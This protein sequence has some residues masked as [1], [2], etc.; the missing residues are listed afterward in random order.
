MGVRTMYLCAY[1]YPCALS[2]IV[3]KGQGQGHTAKDYGQGQLKYLV[4]IGRIGLDMWCP[5][6]W[7]QIC[8]AQMCGAVVPNMWCHGAKN[9]VPAGAVGAKIFL[10]S[11]EIWGFPMRC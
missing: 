11:G 8:G 2:I 4:K 7:F 3:V 1:S 6:V 5:N 10:T 9:V